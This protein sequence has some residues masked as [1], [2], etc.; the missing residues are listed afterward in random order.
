MRILL[1]RDATHGPQDRFRR[2]VHRLVGL[3]DIPG[4]LHDQQ[5]SQL[6]SRI[7]FA[8][9]FQRRHDID[10]L[11]DILARPL[12]D[13]FDALGHLLVACIRR[14]QIGQVE[15][16]R[17]QVVLRPDQRLAELPGLGRRP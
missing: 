6:D 5:V 14:D 9:L 16:L 13:S 10:K 15:Q 2:R 17:D 1:Q 8:L 3:K 7:L 11:C 4:R 12:F